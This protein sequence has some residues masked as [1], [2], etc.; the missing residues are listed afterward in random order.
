MP[1]TCAPGTACDEPRV[2]RRQRLTFWAVAVLLLIL[3]LVAVVVP[4]FYR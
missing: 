4:L 1:R 2:I 3:L